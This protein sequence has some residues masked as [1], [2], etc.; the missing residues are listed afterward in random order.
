MGGKTVSDK[1]LD[2]IIAG[3]REELRA[4]RDEYRQQFD[5]FKLNFHEE[6]KKRDEAISLLEQKNKTLED[7]VTRLEEKIDDAE[8]YERRD[9]VVVSGEAVP[10][11]QTG[12]NCIQVACKLFRDKLNLN[13]S[14]SEVSTA[15]R[16]GKKPSVQGAD[17]RKLILKLCRRDLKKEIIQVCKQVKPGFFVNES[18]TPA[19]N[20]ILYA[21]RQMKRAS[22]SPVKGT[23]TIDGRV[24]AWVE[25]PGASRDLR[26]AVNTR[27][28]LMQFSLQ[29]MNKPLSEYVTEWP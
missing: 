17:R 14:P 19:R 11:A 10:P 15:H 28:K 8:A 7:Y 25:A 3:I 24:F 23:A 13:V 16:L 27:A 9:C 18:L 1:Q 12:E 4:F 6:M 22:N 2:T 29:H 20:T 21:L 5:E 26:V